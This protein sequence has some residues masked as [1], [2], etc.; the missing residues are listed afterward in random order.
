MDIYHIWCSL[1]PGESDTEFADAAHAYLGHLRDE[2]RLS[3]FRITRRKLG[4]GHPNLPEWN[5]LLEFDDLAQMD[6]AFSKVASRA[7]PVESFHHAVN[8]KVDEIF[9]ALYRDFPDSIRVRGD[10]KF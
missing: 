6:E 2:G 3:G 10:E 9:F 1:K 5:I 4:L 8:S 7:D